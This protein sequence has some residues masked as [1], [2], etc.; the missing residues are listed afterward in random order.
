M[1]WKKAKELVFKIGR[2]T[3]AKNRLSFFSFRDKNTQEY[4]KSF[5]ILDE[6]TVINNLDK[7]FASKDEY[8]KHDRRPKDNRKS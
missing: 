6:Q 5:S 4:Y 7:F 8:L 3:Y 1:S 2:D